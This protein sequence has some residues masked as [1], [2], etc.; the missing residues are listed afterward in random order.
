[1]NGPNKEWIES[2]IKRVI[3]ERNGYKLVECFNLG[4]KFYSVY[5][6]FH[7]Y[8]IPELNIDSIDIQWCP[9]DSLSKSKERFEEWS[10]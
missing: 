10:K 5:N 4:C 1:M 8:K 6:E 3:D 9:S 7:H 2:I